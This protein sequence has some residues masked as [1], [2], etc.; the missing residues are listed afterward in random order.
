MQ[1]S[2]S[3]SGLSYPG[4]LRGPASSGGISGVMLRSTS[5][6]RV[7]LTGLC[8][9]AVGVLGCCSE[10]RPELEGEALDLLLITLP[11]GH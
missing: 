2:P 4:W 8:S 3:K 7:R 5:Q 10:E 1:I 11:Y 6:V 9:C